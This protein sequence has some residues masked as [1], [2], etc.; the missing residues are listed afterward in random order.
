MPVPVRRLV[1]DLLGRVLYRPFVGKP[2]LPG[3]GNAA[4]AG[5]S[6][7]ESLKST[8]SGSGPGPGN[9]VD[10][11]TCV[12]VSPPAH[13]NVVKLMRR[14]ARSKSASVVAELPV[15]E[16]QTPTPGSSGDASNKSNNGTPLQ[17]EP[18]NEPRRVPS[19]TQN[20]TPGQSKQSLNQE[21]S[22]VSIACAAVSGQQKPAST[23]QETG[24][25]ATV[26]GVGQDS[27]AAL[28]AS[29][30]S[31]LTGNASATAVKC[32]DTSFSAPVVAEVQEHAVRAPFASK[33]AMVKGI[34]FR[35]NRGAIV[36]IA[37]SRA[38]PRDP[39]R[40]T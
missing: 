36:T 18:A 27:R 11:D 31:T 35:P 20:A 39:N 15:I 5:F 14:S 22:P 4:A 28:S 19:P 40:G 9:G 34:M 29:T 10:V 3:A 16:E 25:C 6:A 2:V 37:K 7:H 1:L 38:P 30:A 26:A 24:L 33:V 32:E 12:S 23:P 17:T 21:A 8:P 13:L